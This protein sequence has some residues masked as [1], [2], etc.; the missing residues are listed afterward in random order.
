[1][2]DLAPDIGRTH[3]IVFLQR[4]SRAINPERK[5]RIDILAAARQAQ[6]ITIAV[7]AAHLGSCAG[8]FSDI[9]VITRRQVF[10][11]AAP[12]R[13]GKRRGAG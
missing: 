13:A 5:A 12:K 1:M 6:P 8:P 10:H 9:Q 4:G 2:P 11:G 7:N 3:F